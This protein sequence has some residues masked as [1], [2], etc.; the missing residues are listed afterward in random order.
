MMM[1]V[2]MLMI[3]GVQASCTSKEN[4][5]WQ[6]A[7]ARGDSSSI[8]LDLHLY[9][10]FIWIC[11]CWCI[12]ICICICI[13]SFICIC[14]CIYICVCIFLQLE[15]AP[16]DSSALIWQPICNSQ[17][18]FLICLSCT[19]ERCSCKQRCVQR[20][21]PCPLPIHPC[22]FGACKYIQK[23]LSSQWQSVAQDHKYMIGTVCDSTW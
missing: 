15:P 18:L 10:S 7:P 22:H 14:I 6:L 16:G 9:F 19:E 13:F 3:K 5:F 4:C 23:H 8:N 20:S 21:N 1:M 12:C 2:P 17:C 11:I